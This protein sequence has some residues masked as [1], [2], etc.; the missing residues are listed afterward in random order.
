MISLDIQ[1]KLIIF[2]FIFGFLFSIILDW[3]YHLFQNKKNIIRNI[4]SFFL[5]FLMSIIYFIGLK[6]IGNA[7][8][9]IYSILFIIMGFISFTRASQEKTSAI[10][11]INAVQ[12]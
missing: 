12:A 7:T 1:I 2:S 10:I 4:S 3:F 9:H 11:N 6:Q 5:I 8:F